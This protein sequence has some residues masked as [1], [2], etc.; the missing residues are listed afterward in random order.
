[1]QVITFGSTDFNKV[2]SSGF[3]GLLVYKAL[4]Q[5]RFADIL[6]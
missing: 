1:M 2:A 5:E 6:W 4:K 3:R